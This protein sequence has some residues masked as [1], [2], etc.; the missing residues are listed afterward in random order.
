MNFMEPQNTLDCL[1]NRILASKPTLPPPKNLF[2]QHLVALRKLTDGEVQYVIILI[3][4]S[5]C[6]VLNIPQQ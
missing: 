4:L 2:N 1:K 3:T 6:S 5:C